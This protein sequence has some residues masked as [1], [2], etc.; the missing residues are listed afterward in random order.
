MCSHFLFL[1]FSVVLVNTV[2]L[3]YLKTMNTKLL[4]FCVFCIFYATQGVDLRDYAPK[5]SQASAVDPNDFSVYVRAVPQFIGAVTQELPIAFGS[6]NCF[7]TIDLNCSHVPGTNSIQFTIHLD[8]AASLSCMDVLTYA[9]LR[10]THTDFYERK[11]VHTF[12]LENLDAEELEMALDQG[13]NVYLYKDGTLNTIKELWSAI[14]GFWD[15]I[16]PNSKEKISPDEEKLNMHFIDSYMEHSFPERDEKWHTKLAADID[17][18][19]DDVYVMLVSRFDGID[20][21][22]MSCSGGFAGHATLVLRNKTDGQLYVI[23]SGE[24][25]MGAVAIQSNQFMDWV[26]FRVA[27][28]F[29]AMLF[30]LHPTI[31]SSFNVEQAWQR[32]YSLNGLPYG[33]Q[34]AAFAAV[35]T[36]KDGF[37]TWMSPEVMQLLIH[38]L[39]Y[40]KPAGAD[41]LVGQAFNHRLGTTNLN[42]TECIYRAYK[43]KLS[44]ADLVALPEENAYLY[45][46]KP[47]IFCSGLVTSLLQAGG[48]FSTLEINFNEFTPRDLYQINLYDSAW[49][50]PAGCKAADP[51][52]PYCQLFGQWRFDFGDMYNSIPP[53]AHMN[54][55]C[56]LKPPTFDRP[57]NC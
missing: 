30:R 36:A 47:S 44:L 24:G 18:L 40:W 8:D 21:F 14:D 11:G 39:E 43:Q 6:T 23:E 52:L 25:P 49:D 15:L 22:I 4:L 56:P 48:A 3:L 20:S 9:T 53:Y 29:N 31:R 10:T 5:P 32:F 51:K 2:I 55:R 7:S 54:E 12:S 28:Q 33:Y 37:P 27:R 38:M 42:A 46:G 41:L 35:D 26:N 57:A 1:R 17:E 16:F 19:T 45:N 34:T 13:V 50:R